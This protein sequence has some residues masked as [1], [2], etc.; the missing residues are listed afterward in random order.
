LNGRFERMV[1]MDG[2]MYVEQTDGLRQE[3]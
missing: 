1:W 3:C 2:H